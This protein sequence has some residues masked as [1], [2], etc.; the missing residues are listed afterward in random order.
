MLH[1]KSEMNIF[2][3]LPLFGYVWLTLTPPSR[4]VSS[5]MSQPCFTWGHL[6]IPQDLAPTHGPRVCDECPPYAS[7]LKGLITW[8]LTFWAPKKR[9]LK[10]LQRN[11]YNNFC[12]GGLIVFG[13]HMNLIILTDLL[14]DLPIHPSIACW[15]WFIALAMPVSFNTILGSF[16]DVLCY[17][18]PTLASP[19]P[20]TASCPIHS[21]W[22]RTSSSCKWQ[23]HFFSSGQ[24]SLTKKETLSFTSEPAFMSQPTPKRVGLKV[25]ELGWLQGRWHKHHVLPPSRFWHLSR[26]Q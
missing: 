18:F 3:Y 22:F 20:P 7:L 14:K 10:V 26:G 9:C 15:I 21:K 19:L 25:L 5:D 2:R 11:L 4:T 13:R 1:L 6:S 8:L 23:P 17:I 12:S 16:L 24:G